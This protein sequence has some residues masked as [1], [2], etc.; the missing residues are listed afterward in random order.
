MLG[1]PEGTE[2]SEF[3]GLKKK[4]SPVYNPNDFRSA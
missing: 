2:Y 1:V 4:L 3:H